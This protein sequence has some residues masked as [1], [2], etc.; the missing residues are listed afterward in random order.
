MSQQDDS[1]DQ[2]L[3]KDS[4]QL[5]EIRNSLNNSEI[6]NIN[7][8]K[9]EDQ[10]NNINQNKEQIEQKILY[11]KIS[12]IIDDGSYNLKI[13]KIIAITFVAFFING[14]SNGYFNYISVAFQAYYGISN[15]LTGF[16]MS[17]RFLG[18]L[19]GYIITPYLKRIFSRKNLLIGSAFSIFVTHLIIS[20]V[21]NIVIFSLNRFINS[22]FIGII[23]TLNFNVM[24]EYLP[25]KFRNFISLFIW[26]AYDIAI[27]FY[28]VL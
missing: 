17:L 8:I 26:A 13:I 3:I 14:L 12:Q 4:L 22:I 20:L 23:T 10:S 7:L 18:Y 5:N 27:L 9:F 11:G 16:I 19:L 1:N 6:E 15:N 28:L 24:T 2:F 21:R 25:K